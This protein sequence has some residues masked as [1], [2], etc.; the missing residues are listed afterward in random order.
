MNSLFS[1]CLKGQNILLTKL[2]HEIPCDIDPES[3]IPI[4]QSDVPSS[5][6]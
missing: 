3:L 1:N 4:R 6:G 5:A 2:G